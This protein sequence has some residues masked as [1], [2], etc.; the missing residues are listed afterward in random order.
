[1]IFE[2]LGSW[3]LGGLATASS[4]VGTLSSLKNLGEN[5]M[6]GESS[7]GDLLNLGIKGAGALFGGGGGATPEMS[8][9][10]AGGPGGESLPELPA[11]RI[12]A[13]S[14]EF[15]PGNASDTMA[16]AADV[17]VESPKGFLASAW[18]NVKGAGEQMWNRGKQDVQKL[19][20]SHVVKTPDGSIDGWKTGGNVGYTVLKTAATRALANAANGGKQAAQQPLPSAETKAPQARTKEADEALK[21]L[22]NMMHNS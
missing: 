21:E 16:K 13:G 9:V 22:M 18:D 15:N 4:A 19:I 7:F 1:M 14:N 2:A 3:L 12:E 20:D 5:T 17:N 8:D 11:E 10:G 6:N